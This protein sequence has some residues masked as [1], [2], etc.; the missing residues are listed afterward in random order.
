MH[1]HVSSSNAN[2]STSTSR[3]GNNGGMVGS[4]IFL[5]GG[6][7]GGVDPILTNLLLTAARDR[8]NNN[9]FGTLE[10]ISRASLGIQVWM[11]ALRKGRL[12]TVSEFG[13]CCISD[14]DSD[15]DPAPRVLVDLHDV[16]PQEPL[17]SQFSTVLAD[18]QLP[19]FVLRHPETVNAVML[20]ILRLSIEFVVRTS[21]DLG[22]D[23]AEE[24]DI[25]DVDEDD[26]IYEYER[27][28]ECFP[29]EFDDQESVDNMIAEDLAA[30]LSSQWGG[31]V[32]AVQSLDQM[33]GADHGLLDAVLEGEDGEYDGEDDDESNS[34]VSRSPFGF[35]LNDGVWSHSGW[36]LIPILQRRLSDMPEL[37]EL[38]SS[39]GRRPAAEGKDMQRFPPQIRSPRSAMGVE[40]DPLNRDS[41]RGIAMTN[42][43]SEMLPSEAVLLKGSPALRRLFLAK[44]VE[45]KLLG[46]D[47]SGYADVPSRAKSRHT[48]LKRLPSAPGGWVTLGFCVT[49]LIVGHPHQ[50]ISHR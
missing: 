10:D 22:K 18:L 43:L 47:I 25:D 33:F 23:E 2:S 17:F 8:D 11:S 26:N 35:G 37:R 44:K 27:E 36:N 7:A 5:G 39:L 16:W 15:S 14:I 28:E 34:Y 41:V 13:D 12:P 42:S 20:G 40:L 48:Y 31:I 3:S 49:F 9:N 45:S 24:T 21:E 46:Y 19:R 50:I 1:V 38:V 4:S 30:Q 29:L 6:S 32:G